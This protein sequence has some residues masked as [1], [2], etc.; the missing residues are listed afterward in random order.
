MSA[1]EEAVA[2][3][4]DEALESFEGDEDA[5]A[6]LERY[7]DRLRE[8]MR[9][10]LLGMV[11]AGKSTLINALIGE[12]I[13]PTDT[14]EC[15]K[16]VTW[17]RY[18]DTRRVTLYPVRGEPRSL[19]VRRVKGRLEFELGDDT[20]DTVESIVVDWPAKSLRTL[21]LVDTPGIASL[22]E[23]VS[24]KSSDFMLPADAPMAVDAVV[25]L[26][27]H[28]H[29]ADLE[30]LTAL[31]DRSAAQSGAA[32]SVVVLS[33]ADEIGAGRID[34]LLSAG[35]V[36]DRY[37]EDDILR[38]LC[39]GVIPIAG[40]LAQTARS[41]R[42]AEFA[43]LTELAGLDRKARERLLTSADRFASETTVVASTPAVRTTLL[44]RFGLFGIRLASALLR[45]GI[46]DAPTLSRE[47]ARHSGL[48]RLRTFVQERFNE[49]SG[50]L[51]A[52][53]VV[54]GLERLFAA[55]PA[56]VTVALEAGLELIRAGSRD[57]DE[58]RLLDYV[59]SG[60][61]TLDEERLAAAERL[62]GGFGIEPARRLGLDPE[63]SPEQLGSAALAAIE[64]WRTLA[65]HP[66]SGRSTQDLSRGIVRACEG[67]LAE[68]EGSG[69][70]SKLV[71]APEPSVRAGQEADDEGDDREH[72]L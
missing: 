33:R 40:L 66:L 65:Q 41:L 34:S 21:T 48:D 60:A 18:G 29:E 50:F 62:L 28:L 52:S 16:I 12:E 1:I 8:P 36:A 14:G 63:A 37:R 22:S 15:T 46:R 72:E 57:W 4:V 68:Q 70:V 24:A 23:G 27:R 42:Q 31:H 19:P 10:A 6:T 61:S 7:R 44:D 64:E 11:K 58:A 17:Y 71:L 39:A 32:N 5:I 26:M 25:Y 69:A 3:L 55:K 47:L 59:R 9:V 56:G 38:A 54:D 43:A 49:R 53:A 35:T 2:G 13:A 30:F 45:G 67:I 20:H 51:R